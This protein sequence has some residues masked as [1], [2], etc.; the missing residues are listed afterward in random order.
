MLQNL[1]AAV[2]A[3]LTMP[4][5]VRRQSHLPLP[6]PIPISCTHKTVHNKIEKKESR[7][8]SSSSRS[9]SVE[10]T[11]S[12]SYVQCRQVT[13]LQLRDVNYCQCV[14]VQVG[15]GGKSRGVRSVFGSRNSLGLTSVY[16]AHTHS[17][18]QSTPAPLA[19]PLPIS[20]SIS[21]RGSHA[22]SRVCHGNGERA[23]S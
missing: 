19:L 17:V 9:S 10:R 14:E 2:D 13:L 8:S 21:S 20:C 16:L 7:R 4:T 1:N 3:C 18:Q 22:R 5:Y 11:P 15:G 23:C 6:L 12:K